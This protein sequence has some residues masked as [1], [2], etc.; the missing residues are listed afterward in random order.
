MGNPVVHFE[1]ASSDVKKAKQFYSKAFGWKFE[2]GPH[3]GVHITETGA[4]KGIQGFLL[5]RGEYIPDYVSLYVEVE[6]IGK[7]VSSVE[8]AGGTVIRPAFSPDGR[9]KLCI[10]SDPEGHVFTL[11]ERKTRRKSAA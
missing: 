3:K 11:S 4:K 7:A 9:N 5:E 8:K 1:I 10:V 2:K 6:N